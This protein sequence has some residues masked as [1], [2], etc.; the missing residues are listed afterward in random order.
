VTLWLA[1]LFLFSSSALGASVGLPV[2]LAQVLPGSELE[3][4]PLTD[5]RTPIVLRIV[6]AEPMGDGFR[7]DFEYYGLA[8]GSFDLRAYLQRKDRTSMA[9]LPPLRVTIESVLPPGQV[10]PN[11]LELRG[12]PW[13]GGYRLL[14]ILGAVLWLLGLLAVLFVGRRRRKQEQARA[15]PRT[16]ADH[17][18]PLV[19]GAMSG[20]LAHDQLAEL[21]RSLILC[22]T[23][24][25][26]LAATKPAAAL[27]LLR[28]HPEAGPLL[29]QLESW[30]HRP[31]TKGTIDVEALLAPYQHLPPDALPAAPEKQTA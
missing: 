12:S 22:W 24:R 21:E 31:G 15:R 30:L 28:A 23:R 26:H 14:V 1:L 18:R 10:K 2:R 13:L 20:T 19:E 27:P 5:R 7:Y 17:L 9:G 6:A 11:D 4:K 8:P 16:L 3:V 29:M 25:L